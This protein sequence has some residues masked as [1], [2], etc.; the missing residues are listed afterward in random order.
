M[1]LA[2]HSSSDSFLV[3]TRKVLTSFDVTL[4]GGADDIKEICSLRCGG[5]C[6]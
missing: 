1:V 3:V 5:A 2:P 4:P 6:Q